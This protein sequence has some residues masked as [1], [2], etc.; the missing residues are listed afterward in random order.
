MAEQCI[1]TLGPSTEK[2]IAWR[3]EMG[4]KWGVNCPVAGIYALFYL[5][6]G[7]SGRFPELA[8]DARGRRDAKDKGLIFWNFKF[9]IRQTG[10]RRI[11][12]LEVF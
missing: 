6:R 12:E 3:G 2:L 9:G 10:Q 8:R 11:D 1:V 5:P 4:S 7:P